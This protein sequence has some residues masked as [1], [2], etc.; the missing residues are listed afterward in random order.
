MF[1][2][3]AAPEFEQRTALHRPRV[4]GIND[5]AQHRTATAPD[6]HTHASEVE[7]QVRELARANEALRAELRDHCRADAELR[8]AKER[9]TLALEGSRLALWDCD[10]ATESLYL[11]EQWAAMLG[12]PP[13]ETRTTLTELFL[14]TH[15]SEREALFAKYAAEVKGLAP[16]YKAEHRIRARSGQWKWILA[17]AR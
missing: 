15:P 14:L 10:V 7:A 9:L 12:D 4:A 5:G 1:E 16:E 11:S 6:G 2:S 17:T 3:P 13:Q 8:E